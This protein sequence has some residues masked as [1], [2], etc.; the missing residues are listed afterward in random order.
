MAA[1]VE[2]RAIHVSPDVQDMIVTTVHIPDSPHPDLKRLVSEITG[3]SRHL[4]VDFDDLRILPARLLTLMWGGFDWSLEGDN[5]ALLKLALTAQLAGPTGWWDDYS[6]WEYGFRRVLRLRDGVEPADPSEMESIFEK[7]S[8]FKIKDALVFSA[9]LHG[10]FLGDE[11]RREA[12]SQLE[13]LGVF[14]IAVSHSPGLGELKLKDLIGMTK[15][16]ACFLPLSAGLFFGAKHLA[17]D[18]FGLA[19]LVTATGGGMTLVACSTH[20][21]ASKI[22]ERMKRGGDSGSS[23]VKRER[24]EPR[25]PPESNETAKPKATHKAVTRK[26][27]PKKQ[28]RAMPKSKPD[29][30]AAVDIGVDP[31]PKQKRRVEAFVSTSPQLNIDTEVTDETN[32]DPWAT[33]T[34][35]ERAKIHVR[36]SQTE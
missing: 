8:P 14:D 23:P 31:L 25:T 29:E 22:F 12:E 30:H 16:P 21:I 6:L 33:I 9:A 15:W 32:V 1:T 34:E 4:L 2:P 13:A 7:W 27:T 24:P 36:N 10:T 11:Q 28:Q 3:V 26:Q 18:E 20:W 5:A 19:F 35:P 17:T